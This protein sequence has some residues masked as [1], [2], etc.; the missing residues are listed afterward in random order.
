VF[1]SGPV[2]TSDVVGEGDP[3]SRQRVASVEVTESR[4]SQVGRLRV[5]R[6]LPRRA[7]RTVGPWCFIDHMGPATVTEAAGIDVAPHPH[8]G[9]QTVTWLLAG[10]VLHRDSL[11]TEQVI[12]PGQLNLMT[13][14]RGVAHSE[15]RTGRYHGPLHGVQL[16]VAQPSSTR[17][18]SPGFEHHA[19]LPG[20][21][22]EGAVG[23]VL[24]GE[25]GGV[26][27]AARRDTDHV[28][29]DLELRRGSTTVPLRPDFEHALVVFEGVVE[30]DG[31]AVPPGRLAYLGLGRDECGLRVTDAARALLVGGQPFDEPVLMWWNFVARTR[32][33]LVGA[34][35]DWM[36]RDVRFGEVASPLPRI[37]VAPPPWA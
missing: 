37:E 7:R 15:E 36:A 24:V 25:I 4:E 23:T 21:D 9:L 2:T 18:G 33:E 28:G 32:D 19:H 26:A 22:L 13:A 11:G 17:D 6:A 5:R 35:R 27:S 30:V 1:V 8:I 29:V 10:E 12:A 34:H 14:G 3:P 16:W 31:E 20:V